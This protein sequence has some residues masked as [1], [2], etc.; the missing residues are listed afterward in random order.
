MSTRRRKDPFAGK[1]NVRHFRLVHRPLGAEVSPSDDANLKFEDLFE[2]FSPSGKGRENSKISLNE[3]FEEDAFETTEGVD[4]E[5]QDE[6]EVMID[7]DAELDEF[8][9][10]YIDIEGDDEFLERVKPI[11]ESEAVGEAAKFGILYDDRGYDYTK[12]LRRVGITP[13]AVFIQAPGLKKQSEKQQALGDFFSVDDKTGMEAPQS[14]NEEDKEATVKANHEMARQQYRNLLQQVGDDPMLRE[15]IEALEDDR[16]VCEEFD[17]ELV[18]SLDN[19]NLSA[20]NVQDDEDIDILNDEDEFPDFIPSDAMKRQLERIKAQEAQYTYTRENDVEGEQEDEDLENILDEYNYEEEEEEFA[21]T[22]AR[23]SSF[24]DVEAE[25]EFGEDESG[26]VVDEAEAAAIYD[27]LRASGRARGTTLYDKK[28]ASHLPPIHIAIAQY[29]ELRREMAV[30]NDLIIQKYSQED[31]VEADRQMRESEQIIDGLVKFVAQ[32][33]I[34]IQTSKIG[35]TNEKPSA[36]PKKIVERTSSSKIKETIAK[37]E[38]SDSESDEASD[39]EPE[40]PVNKG[41]ARSVDET[42]EEK[43]ARKARI[44]EEKREKR[45]EKK[46]KK[47]SK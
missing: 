31:E 43:R 25:S 41:I 10:R 11:L 21:R 40:I 5:E 16:Y 15:V 6:E 45:V 14:E 23:D 7:I 38:E 46:N 4:I 34:N 35:G 22:N 44:K 39:E 24:I 20:G 37:Q 32:D 2:E 33:R 26:V 36:G 9:E 30:N 1:E 29:N 42:A 19:L 47:T 28:R 27:F 17:D 13:G 3:K 18:V 8:T 12:H